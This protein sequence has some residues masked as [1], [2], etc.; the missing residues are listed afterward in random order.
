MALR[1]RSRLLATQLTATCAKDGQRGLQ[2]RAAF[3]RFFKFVDF[4]GYELG[5]LDQEQ[6]KAVKIGFD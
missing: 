6:R 4:E 5:R 1:A 2:G 3:E